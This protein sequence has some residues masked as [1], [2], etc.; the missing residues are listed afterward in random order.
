MGCTEKTTLS[1][2]RCTALHGIVL[3]GVLRLCLSV[4]TTTS[5]RVDHLCFLGVIF[6]PKKVQDTD[7]PPWRSKNSILKLAA[8]RGDARRVWCKLIFGDTHRRRE[9]TQRWE[10]RRQ[11]RTVLCSTVLLYYVGFSPALS[12]PMQLSPG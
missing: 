4:Q 5:L 10:D 12:Q 9:G 1:V 6:T 2:V 7:D 11:P 8:R 3:C